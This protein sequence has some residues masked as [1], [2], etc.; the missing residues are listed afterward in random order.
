MSDN[1]ASTSAG[2]Q[3]DEPERK[4]PK[5]GEGEPGPF[6]GVWPRKSAG[7]SKP[8]PSADRGANTTTRGTA[9]DAPD[10]P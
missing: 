1:Y 3:T 5:G 7:K 10:R 6:A 4:P 9:Q 8:V 2:T